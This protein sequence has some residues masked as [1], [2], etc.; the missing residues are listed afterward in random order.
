MHA[1]R[2][3]HRRLESGH[4]ECALNAVM[5]RNANPSKIVAVRDLLREIFLRF[6]DSERELAERRSEG[7]D[8]HA[9]ALEQGESAEALRKKLARAV[10][11]S[12][13]STGFVTAVLS[14]PAPAP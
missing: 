1:D 12:A 11:R 13:L 7:V 6:D 2:R 9:I 5:Q 3:D 8:W 14:H 10:E 4:A